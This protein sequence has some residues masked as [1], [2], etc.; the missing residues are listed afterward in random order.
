MSTTATIASNL[1]TQVN[2]LGYSS[3]YSFGLNCLN[4]VKILVVNFYLL[5]PLP[6]Y[7]KRIVEHEQFFLLP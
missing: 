5:P 2:Y 6:L 7:T 3:S 4:I 1:I